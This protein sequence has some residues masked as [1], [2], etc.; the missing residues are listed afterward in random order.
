MAD[1]IP[2]LEAERVDET[3]SPRRAV[4]S[5]ALPVLVLNRVFSPVRL[6]TARR[7]LSLMYTG[8]AHGLD[9]QGESL[10]FTSWRSLAIREGVDDAVT[11]V[12]GA[13][14]VPRVVH[15]RRFARHVQPTVRLTRHNLMLRDGFRC[16]YCGRAP[17]VRDLDIDHV[18]PRSRGGR[19]T[20]ENLV[21]ACHP[22]NR[23]KRDATPVEAG[24]PLLRPPTA[25][26]WSLAAQV[27][28]ALPASYKEWEPFLRAS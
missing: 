20:W 7:A 9:E 13:L 6:T 23:T 1:G 28:G 17:H 24:M 8:I 5:L 2:A 15:V 18:H 4:D 21:T 12:H 19:D 14:R 25:P 10:E 26:R 11:L 27:L 22:C 16:Q 3:T